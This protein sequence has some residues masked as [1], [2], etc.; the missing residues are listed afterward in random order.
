MS[1]NEF[2]DNL[3]KKRQKSHEEISANNLVKYYGM[4]N[5]FSKEKAGAI[6]FVENFNDTKPVE[7]AVAEV[8]GKVESIYR[9]LTPQGLETVKDIIVKEREKLASA[10]DFADSHDNYISE[11]GNALEI[12]KYDKAL[13]GI[14]S[15]MSEMENQ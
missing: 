11:A 10:P 5:D 13:N 12:L 6:V 4:L 3:A 7:E 8:N 9:D 15:F 2:I 1:Y 14:N